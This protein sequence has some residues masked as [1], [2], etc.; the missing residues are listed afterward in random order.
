[1]NSQKM[2]DVKCLQEDIYWQRNQTNYPYFICNYSFFMCYLEEKLKFESEGGF[3]V[4]SGKAKMIAFWEEKRWQE[5]RGGKKDE[6]I[7]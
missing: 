4:F 3:I 6:A 2:Q 1:M 5:M 7:H